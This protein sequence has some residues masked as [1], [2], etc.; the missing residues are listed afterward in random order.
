[1]PHDGRPGRS[2]SK[3]EGR[4]GAQDEVKAEP[5]QDDDEMQDYAQPNSKTASFLE[6]DGDADNED[7]PDE[8]PPKQIRSVELGSDEVSKWVP[9]HG[10]AAR[11]FTRWTFG[12]KAGKSL[13]NAR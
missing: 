13:G 5:G 7:P 11:R 8:D 9:L 3:P 6:G 12:I 2:L 10:K 4:P 1:M